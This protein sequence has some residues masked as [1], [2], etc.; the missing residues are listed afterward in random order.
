M[1]AHRLTGSRCRCP[2]CGEYFN[3]TSVFDRHRVGAWTARG[4]HRRCLSVAEMT[5]RGWSITAKG[6][7]I[8]RRRAGRGLDVPRRSGDLPVPGVRRLPRGTPPLTHQVE[9]SDGP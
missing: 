3:S 1:I 9:G 5:G 6:F 8:E 2:T 7:W 4:T